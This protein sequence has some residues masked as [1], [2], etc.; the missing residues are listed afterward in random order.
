MKKSIIKYKKSLLLSFM[1]I[2]INVDFFYQMQHSYLSLLNC[3]SEDRR[4]LSVDDSKE[5]I[6]LEDSLEDIMLNVS[7]EN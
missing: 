4:E 1:I 5:C 6:F 3:S 2:R 7:P